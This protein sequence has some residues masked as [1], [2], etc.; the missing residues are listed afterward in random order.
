MAVAEIADN[1][2]HATNPNPTDF[3]HEIHHIPI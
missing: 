1:F 3:E 2:D